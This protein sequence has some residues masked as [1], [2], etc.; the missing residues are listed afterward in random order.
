MFTLVLRAVTGHMTA[1]K[2]NRL[3]G[4][5]AVTVTTQPCVT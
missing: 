4:A 3:S 5:L 1:L 2:S